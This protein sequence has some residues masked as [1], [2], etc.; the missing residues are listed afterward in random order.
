MSKLQSLLHDYLSIN[1]L[2][3][4]PIAGGG[5]AEVAAARPDNVGLIHSLEQHRR[6]NSLLIITIVALDVV[7]FALGA[8]VTLHNLTE[9]TAVAT[10]FGCT[11]AALLGLGAKL[12]KLWTE[13]NLIEMLRAILPNLAPEEGAKAILSLYYKLMKGEK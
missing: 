4:G 11:F 10:T 9:P 1:G 13:N 8:Y 3:R 5:S 7:L 2:L 12:Q 6:T